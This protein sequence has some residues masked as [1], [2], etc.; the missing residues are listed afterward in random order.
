[1]AGAVDASKNAVTRAAEATA[2]GVGT[3]AKE[4]GR[5]AERAGSATKSAAEIAA[6]KTAGA[7]VAAGTATA[8]GARAVGRKISSLLLPGGR[9]LEV[10][11]GSVSHNLATYLGSGGA[12]DVPRTFVFD[13]LNFQSGSTRLI[14]SS[15]DT[16][17]ELVAI[18]KA[19]SGVDVRLDGYTDN[20]GNAD[21]NVRLSRQRAEA[22]K[23]MMTKAG[24]EA[25][26]IST[27]GHG[28]DKPVATNDTPDGRQQN[29]RIELTVTKK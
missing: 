2:S 10:E 24:V 16:V 27:D 20:T 11:E 17:T 1:V 28:Q 7:A 9:K 12:G 26:R 6:E 14:P 4:V 25:G 23:G 18:L 19:H 29:R 13:H 22:V 15:R 21:A 8:H 5:A 3:A